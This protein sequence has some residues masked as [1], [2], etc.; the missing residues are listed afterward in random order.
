[1]HFITEQT[2]ENGRWRSGRFPLSALSGGSV[3][4]EKVS[5]AFFKAVI[6][7]LVIEVPAAVDLYQSFQTAAVHLE[8]PCGFNCTGPAG[9]KGELFNSVLTHGVDDFL[10]ILVPDNFMEIEVLI[11]AFPGFGVATVHS[12]EGIAHGVNFRTP[13]FPFRP[14]GGRGFL[15]APAVGLPVPSDHVLLLCVGFFK[16]LDHSV[17]LN[18]RMCF[19]LSVVTYSL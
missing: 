4:A 12:D 5:V 6:L 7:A 17:F 2:E 15:I 1:M 11:A 13:G 19:S 16:I 3:Y 14:D 10:H 8:K 18:F 9:G